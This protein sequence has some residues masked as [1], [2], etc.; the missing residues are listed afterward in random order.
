MIRPVAFVLTVGFI[1]AAGAQTPSIKTE[2][3]Q[4]YSEAVRCNAKLF[5]PANHSVTT[6]AAAVV[7]APGERATRTSVEQ[8]A[9][10][11]AERGIVALAIDYRG[12]GECGGF[13]YFG[14][15]VRWDDR[16]RFMQMTTTMAIR[17]GRVDPQA[18]V[19]DIRNAVTFLQGVPGV[20]RAR[21]GL[22]GVDLAGGHAIVTA[23]SDARVKAV[24][25]QMPL[26]AGQNTSRAAFAPTPKQRALMIKLARSGAV[27]STE[28]AA[29]A[30]NAE[31]AQLALA[32]YQPFW[33][34]EQIPEST[35]VLFVTREGDENANEVTQ[36][37][38]TL[39]GPT[40]VKTLAGAKRGV[41]G[42]ET[43][44]AS[45]AAQWFVSHLK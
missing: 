43:E 34:L 37:S 16:L 40:V 3:V 35:A 4:Y 38:N 1:A 41:V 20:D 45:A 33:Y 28:R 2:V 17:R 11:F 42:K 19:I 6:N 27:P 5:T 22:W 9:Q 13:L 21:I 10:A 24:V 30:M 15:P 18:Q 25:A 26:L 39:K 12:W 36:A 32:D 14:E 23:G 29:K 7:L 8:Y 31:E 44:A